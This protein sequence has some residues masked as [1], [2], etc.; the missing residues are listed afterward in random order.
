MEEATILID[1]I[2]VDVSNSKYDGP[3]DWDN[4]ENNRL[5]D[6]RILQATR[7]SYQQSCEAGTICASNRDMLQS[8]FEASTHRD[9]VTPGITAVVICM[10][11]IYARY[12]H[13]RRAARLEAKSGNKKRYEWTVTSGRPNR[14]A[15]LSLETSTNDEAR[16][17]DINT[18]EVPPSPWYNNNNSTRSAVT[19]S[20][21]AATGS[22]SGNDGRTG[23]PVASETAKSIT[24]RT[25]IAR[26]AT[27][28]LRRKWI[29]Q[30]N[31]NNNHH[32]STTA[33]S[34]FEPKESV[35]QQQLVVIDSRKKAN[36]SMMDTRRNNDN[37][38]AQ[39]NA[40]VPVP[41]NQLVVAPPQNHEVNNTALATMTTDKNTN[42]NA[43]KK[44][45]TSRRLSY[46][47]LMDERKHQQKQ[48]AHTSGI[49]PPTPRH[50]SK[51]NT[52]SSHLQPTSNL[53]SL[54]KHADDLRHGKATTSA[55]STA[56]YKRRRNSGDDGRN[57][58]NATVG[59]E[60]IQNGHKSSRLASPSKASP[61]NS[62]A[63]N[64][65]VKFANEET[66]NQYHYFDKTDA[67]NVEMDKDV[68]EEQQEHQKQNDA[69]MEVLLEQAS[70]TPPPSRNDENAQGAMVIHAGSTPH[71]VKKK[72]AANGKTSSAIVV[73]KALGDS[74]NITSRNNSNIQSRQLSSKSALSY[75]QLK[76]KENKQHKQQFI[77]PPMMPQQHVS[78]NL[79]PSNYQRIS[80][81]IALP[82]HATK[83]ELNK[84]DGPMANVRK[85]RL[86]AAARIN[87]ER[88]E[89]VLK[90]LNQ[91]IPTPGK[92]NTN[93]KKGVTF[94]TAG[95]SQAAVAS[96]SLGAAPAAAA[97][98][99]TAAAKPTTVA[100]AP[101]P[102]ISFAP[103]IPAAAATAASATAPA[104]PETTSFTF[105]APTAA[106]A[107]SAP[108][109]TTAAAPTF[110][111]GAAPASAPP[112][113]SMPATTSAPSFAF[114]ATPA[115][116]ATSVQPATTS[117]APSF[118]FGASAPAAPAAPAPAPPA[119]ATTATPSFAFGAAPPPAPATTSEAP[120]FAFGAT[121]A[122]PPAA[123]STP[124]AAPVF[125]F[126][127]TT[128]PPAQAFG[129]TT[130]PA[131]PAFGAPTAFAAPAFAAAAPAA[132]AFAPTAAPTPAF[133]PTAP[134][135]S[136][137]PAFG[138]TAPAPAF[139]ATAPAPA[140]GATA[141]APAFG[142]PPT[143][144]FG[145]AAAAGR[146]PGGASSRRRARNKKKK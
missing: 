42:L 88:N 142:A 34:S 111:F 75:Q 61:V 145:V 143:P 66:I 13:K 104:P 127:A 139:G 60:A 64:N 30:S 100:V 106:A 146:T 103:P 128:A 3:L 92:E 15:P 118:A 31:H 46:S 21:L 22:V 108:A 4:D 81:R 113:A 144:A 116:A 36:A 121:T 120:G 7:K 48:N 17:G 87:R 45:S 67:P 26:I 65:N 19:S 38:A 47:Q 90:S 95:L 72:S 68:N 50:G 129:A 56:S 12:E 140:F 84:N 125:A 18:V 25:E 138:A 119:T 37:H 123:T 79:R 24:Q 126:N 57:S 94:G 29:D 76:T 122:P 97:T 53:S 59:Y 93:H 1:S 109:K 73:K 110:A 132:P 16:K 35:N 51:V 137:T 71:F 83:H 9:L 133:A 86:M 39:S 20:V 91:P 8:P 54:L 27:P 117:A 58:Y 135:F 77:V 102:A 10:S 69:D 134:A 89:R 32:Q 28:L 74:T 49:Q 11:L 99:G 130:A 124:A 131:A 52:S 2:E 141:P 96:Q 82:L 41:N 98:F 33:V 112:A 43:K 70:N 85:Q 6:Q 62:H 55:T 107:P 78:L 5:P 115:P 136:A 23:T 63:Q 14:L 44:K 114:G 40:L 105:A 101:T 80:G